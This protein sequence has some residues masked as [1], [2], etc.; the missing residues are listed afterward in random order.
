MDGLENI[1][2]KSAKFAIRKKYKCER[3]LFWIAII[4]IFYIEFLTCIHCPSIWD[5]ET[6]TTINSLTSQLLLAYIASYIFFY[7]NVIKREK[8]RIRNCY[9]Q[10][11]HI[12]K[13]LFS[14]YESHEKYLK[15][16]FNK[17]RKG[18]DFAYSTESF[19]KI[20]NHLRNE[21][22]VY[23]EA[24]K[25][26]ID[27]EYKPSNTI[28]GSNFATARQI[29]YDIE[30]LQH[31]NDIFN[32]DYQMILFRIS[33]NLYILKYKNNRINNLDFYET[34]IDEEITLNKEI[35]ELKKQSSPMFGM[36]F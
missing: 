31:F 12:L 8:E 21:D 19:Q 5:T 36:E 28:G 13:N 24:Y 9:P 33:Q 3:R 35:Q 2:K 4:G 34:L 16:I 20:I 11:I 14:V 10:I 1:I 6:C 30:L 15:S 22:K 17:L 26:P 32:S 27:N 25:L 29:S 23:L 18:E 7:L